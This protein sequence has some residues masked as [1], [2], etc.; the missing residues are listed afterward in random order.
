MRV[1]E[2]GRQLREDREQTRFAWTIPRGEYLAAATEENT[3]YEDVEKPLS[4]L[5]DAEEKED[6]ALAAWN[7]RKVNS[8]RRAAQ[9]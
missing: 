4:A 2:V 6:K 3:A 8:A 9:R 1:N 7:E 5:A